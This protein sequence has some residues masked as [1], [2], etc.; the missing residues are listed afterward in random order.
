MVV[1]L[2]INACTSCNALTIP[3]RVKRRL[4]AFR[5][6][7]PFFI[8]ELLNSRIMH[9]DRDLLLRL[10]EEDEDLH[11]VLVTCKTGTYDTVK[12]ALLEKHIR[13]LKS[14]SGDMDIALI[15]L[16]SADLESIQQIQDIEA[17]EHDGEV[18]IDPA[19]HKESE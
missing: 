17:I 19:S 12:Q 18:F 9:I 1:W 16:R 15:L 5:E 14:G 7:P 10:K 11:R 6:R 2:R 4:F 3:I 8:Q 13:V